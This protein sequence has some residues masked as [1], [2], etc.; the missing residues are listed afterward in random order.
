MARDPGTHASNV[1]NL[2]AL[3]HLVRL[4]PAGCCCCENVILQG[5]YTY[6]KVYR[7]CTPAQPAFTGLIAMDAAGHSPEWRL[8]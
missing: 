3:D 1:Y 8:Q 6:I 2:A 5:P 7:P 4:A